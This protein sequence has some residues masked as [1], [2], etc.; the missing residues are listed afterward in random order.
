M[1]PAGGVEAARPLH[2]ILHGLGPPP[3]PQGPAPPG[4]GAGPPSAPEERAA[5]EDTRQEEEAT[6]PTA[7]P[8]TGAVADLQRRVEQNEELIRDYRKFCD[9][10]ERKNQQCFITISE[11]TNVAKELRQEVDMYSGRLTLVCQ[12]VVAL[13]QQ[14][15]SLEQALE[16]WTSK[17]VET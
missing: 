6:R 17:K 9:E 15:A 2:V 7:T 12:D 1:D 11:L 5:I 8:T 4:L 16:W 10:L 3:P 13:K 14:V